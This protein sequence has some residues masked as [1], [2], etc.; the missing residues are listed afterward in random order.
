MR[1][2]IDPT[3]MSKEE[4]TALANYL[5][6]NNQIG[7]NKSINQSQAPEYLEKN[8]YHH[9]ILSKESNTEKQSNKNFI[10]THNLLK[11]NISEAE[12]EIKSKPRPKS[13]LPF[14]SIETIRYF[15]ISNDKKPL[16]RGTF[17]SIRPII[18]YIEINPKTLESNFIPQAGQLVVRITNTK[19]A[20]TKRKPSK[21]YNHVETLE[22]YE[23][24][25]KKFPHIEMKRPVK[26]T[27]NYGNGFFDKSYTIMAFIPGKDFYDTVAD[28]YDEY[29]QKDELPPISLMVDLTIS[30]LEAYK[31][32]IADEE[33]AHRDI[34]GE[35]ILIAYHKDSTDK[36]P[37][38]VSYI[39]LDSALPYDKKPGERNDYGFGSPGFI[40][41]EIILQKKQLPISVN[42]KRDIFSLGVIATSVFN[43]QL[44]PDFCFGDHLNQEELLYKASDFVVQ[45][46]SYD[47]DK[48]IEEIIARNPSEENSYFFQSVIFPE[49]NNESV[50][51]TLGEIIKQQLKSMTSANP[52][53]RPTIESLITAFKNIKQVLNDGNKLQ[54]NNLMSFK[55][56]C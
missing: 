8:P 41:P 5:L 26:V 49:G 20:Q 39:D 7:A 42:Q 40:A 51:T 48:L 28:I 54:E 14:G 2:K 30:L 15:V 37:F 46:K 47:P 34:R 50:E 1:F 13:Q 17:S 55:L 44:Y 27:K 43:I 19:N 45:N 36:H 33:Y 38:S 52:D 6:T 22:L 21:P 4:A 3:N 25:Y 12:L 24:I 16:A 23:K 31:T 29:Q 11:E 56:G 10:I 9:Q 53:E 35:N 18:G 32:Q